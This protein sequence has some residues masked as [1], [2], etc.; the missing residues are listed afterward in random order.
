MEVAITKHGIAADIL[1]FVT[2]D[3]RIV[4]FYTPVLSVGLQIPLGMSHHLG[5][6]EILLKETYQ[7]YLK[8]LQI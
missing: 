7:I 1:S 5:L 8:N 3:V 6:Q 4:T 2:K